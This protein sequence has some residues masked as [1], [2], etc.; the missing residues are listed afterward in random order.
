MKIALIVL[1]SIIVGLFLYFNLR[2][3][4]NKKNSILLGVLG[5]ICV[6]LA[7]IYTNLLDKKNR[8]DAEIIATFNR[9]EGVKCGEIVIDSENFTF[10]N[11]TLSFM[12]K[13]KTKYSGVII[14]IEDCE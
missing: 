12:G 1:V 4:L 14:S 3:K 10:T 13:A 9:G 11:G 5:A 8:A 2:G 7:I 6:I